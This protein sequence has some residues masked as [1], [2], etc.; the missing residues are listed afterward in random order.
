MQQSS[1]IHNPYVVATPSERRFANERRARQERIRLAAELFEQRRPA[2]PPLNP[3]P[4]IEIKEVEKIEPVD[5]LDQWKERQKQIPLP[6]MIKE[7]FFSIIGEIL[8]D[9][10]RRPTISLIQRVTAAYCGITVIEIM[11][12]GRTAR[13]VRARHLAIYFAR[14]LTLNSLTEIGRRFGG[15]D[16][17]T[18]LHGIRKIELLKGSDPETAAFLNIVHAAIVEATP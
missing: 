15:R 10:P 3:L 5:A 18:I 8:P 4:V 9:E 1:L 6:P 14:E 11:A 13:V 17:A 12:A 16:H 7:P 2:A